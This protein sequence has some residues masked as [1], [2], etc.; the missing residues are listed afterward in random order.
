MHPMESLPDLVRRDDER[1]AF[2]LNRPADTFSPA[3]EKAGM[4]GHNR[5]AHHLNPR[6]SRD[7][8]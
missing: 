5:G 7:A 4:R 3:G 1:P 6:L 8:A 2:P